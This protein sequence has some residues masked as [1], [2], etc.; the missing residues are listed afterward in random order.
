MAEPRE[1]HVLQLENLVRKV[2]LQSAAASDVECRIL[3]PLTHGNPY[4]IEISKER[5][6]RRVPVDLLVVKRLNLGQP[7][8]VLMRDLRAAILAVNR[9][10]RRRQ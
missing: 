10:A 3:V 5:F 4:I 2:K 6:V 9:L 1:H 8:P 7:D